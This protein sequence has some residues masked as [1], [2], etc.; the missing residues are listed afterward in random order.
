MMMLIIITSAA[1]SPLLVR[2]I[3]SLTLDLIDIGGQWC[4]IEFPPSSGP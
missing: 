1:S 3:F 2:P 4:K